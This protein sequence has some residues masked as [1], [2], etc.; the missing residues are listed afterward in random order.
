MCVFSGFGRKEVVEYLLQ[1]GADVHVKDDGEA[2]YL[3]KF[4]CE[5]IFCKSELN[6]T[7]KLVYISIITM[8][9][10]H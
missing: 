6:Q 7:N 9:T 3:I 5:T 10:R 1:C 2:K 8:T 4:H